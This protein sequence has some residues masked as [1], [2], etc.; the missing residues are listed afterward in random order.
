LHFGLLA[1]LFAAAGATAMAQQEKEGQRHRI[2]LIKELIKDVSDAV[3]TNQDGAILAVDNRDERFGRVSRGVLHGILR[4][5]MLSPDYSLAQPLR[6]FNDHEPVCYKSIDLELIPTYGN[7][8]ASICGIYPITLP[9]LK[10]IQLELN[11]DRILDESDRN[12]DMQ[13]FVKIEER[14]RKG[15]WRESAQLQANESRTRAESNRILELGPEAGGNPELFTT[16]AFTA[17]LS[18]WAGK[19]IQLVLQAENPNLQKSPCR[20]RWLQAKLVGATFDF[21]VIVNK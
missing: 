9:E 13:F 5:S 16:H 1:I 11:Y 4:H 18:P 14:D 10:R 7:E 8:Y 19:E 3:W 20:G 6:M 12:N 21:N 2:V 17:N 15:E